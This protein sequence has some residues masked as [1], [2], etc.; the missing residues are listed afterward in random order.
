M[1]RK[2]LLTTIALIP[3]KT[4][5]AGA[6]DFRVGTEM[7]ELTYLTQNSSFGYG[8]ADIGFGALIKVLRS[9]LVAVVRATSMGYILVWEQ[10]PMLVYW[11]AQM[12][13]WI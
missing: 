10:R 12:R 2:V 8:G 6:I 13:C 9:L 11:K 7:A 3:F 4:L 1:L 5:Y